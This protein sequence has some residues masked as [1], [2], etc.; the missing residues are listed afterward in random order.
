MRVIHHR[1]VDY[2]PYI[3]KE[4]IIFSS[5]SHQLNSHCANPPYDY[6][7]GNKMKDNPLNGIDYLLQGFSLIFK[8]ELRAYIIMPIL[9]NIVLFIALFTA[10]IHY[11]HQFVLWFNHLLPHWLH[12]LQWILWFLF[13]ILILTL[14]AY[15]FTFLTNLICTPFNSLLSE[16]VESYL[17][18]KPPETASIWQSIPR[19]IGRQLQLIMYYLLRASILFLLS[20]TPIIHIFSAIAWFLFTAW[21]L[22]IQYIDYP[23][24]NHHISF[25]QLREKLQQKK[26]LS[27]SFGI[28]ILLF[29]YIPIINLLVM[30]AAVAGATKMYLEENT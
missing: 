12:W 19:S 5:A 18:G 14:Y 17:T 23:M 21:M 30:P 15:T 11:F 6:F 4:I 13:S 25:M 16:K 3:K 10:G 1:F 22:T 20:F 8:R 26:L 24:D 27:L 28:S 7:I 29:I 9:I 2:A